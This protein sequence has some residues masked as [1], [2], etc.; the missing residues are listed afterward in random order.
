VAIEVEK[1]FCLTKEQRAAVLERLA[2]IGAS[3]KGNEFEENVLYEGNQIDPTKAVLRLRRVGKH[4]FLTFKQR[5][6]T[7]SDIK[8][9]QEDETQVADAD[10][11]DAILK[12]LGYTPS[13]VYEK[14]RIT[15]ELGN[16][17]IVVDDLPFGLFMEI[18][19][20]E[21]EINEIEQKLDI[22]DL[23]VEH[24]TYPTLTRIHGKKRDDGVIESRFD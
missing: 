20:P 9:R 22:Q 19:G 24:A 11:M 12:D 4:G 7:N 13:L 2:K 5:A 3:L 6:P 18:E 21:A 8:Y 1:K 10:A 15:W 14:R 16:G 17:E 23:K